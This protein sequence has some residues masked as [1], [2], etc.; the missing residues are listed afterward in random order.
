VNNFVVEQPPVD[1]PPW[2]MAGTFPAGC[3]RLGGPAFP[4]GL[5]HRIPRD[6]SRRHAYATVRRLFMVGFASF[7][8]QIVAIFQQ[9][10][11]PL[12]DLI[13]KLLGGITTG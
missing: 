11:G 2:A 9:L 3:P 13:A 6:A 8:T 5:A 4:A 10:I 12:F 7:F 1:L